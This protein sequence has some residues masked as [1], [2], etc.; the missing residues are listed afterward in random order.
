MAT[1]YAGKVRA[2]RARADHH[3][4]PSLPERPAFFVTAGQRGGGK[5]TVINMVSVAVLGRTGRRGCLVA[6]RRGAPQSHVRLSWRRG[7]AA[8]VGQHPARRCHLLPIDR[9]GTNRRDL[10]GPGAWLSETR[11]VPATTIQVF[12]GNNITPR[13]DMASRSLMARLAVDRPDPENR[14]SSTLIRSPGLRRTVAELSALYTILRGNPRL[15]ADNPAPAKTRFKM[16]WHLVGSAIEYAAEQHDATALPERC[17]R[18]HELPTK[19][20]QFLRHALGR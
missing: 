13:G 8:R 7:R 1:D 14:Y 9:K 17:H 2:D 10:Q 20:D 6:Q 4:T 18:D 3:R 15:H 11:T 5:T 19:D 16:W 12:T